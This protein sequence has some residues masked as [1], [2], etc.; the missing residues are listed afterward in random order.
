MNTPD[1]SQEKHLD[2]QNRVRSI[3]EEFIRVAKKGF[4][5]YL[6]PVQA[7]I[8]LIAFLV[9]ASFARSDSDLFGFII[10][11]T[12]AFA[13]LSPFSYLFVPRW[14]LNSGL[15]IGSLVALT[16]FGFAI[17]NS[18]NLPGPDIG[19]GMIGFLAVFG[20]PFTA[21]PLAGLIK[22]LLDAR[23][24]TK[25]SENKEDI[26]TGRLITISYVTNIVSFFLGGPGWFFK[27]VI[28][29]VF[30]VINIILPVGAIT[31]AVIA[32][33]QLNDLD[34]RKKQR[35]LAIS[36]IVIAVVMTIIHFIPTIRS[37]FAF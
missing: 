12:I 36:S 26:K 32:F 5:L 22:I 2:N 16:I 7:L 20:G 27:E 15:Y 31:L 4:Y 34:D 14:W 29:Y 3:K 11:V 37:L 25:A 24:E 21:L 10:V 33:R 28:F 17:G 1:Q 8:L 13:F 19:E 23:R 18:A 6:P 30:L 9:Y 35:N